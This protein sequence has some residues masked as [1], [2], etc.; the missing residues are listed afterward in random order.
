MF[1]ALTKINP[2]AIMDTIW[3][4]LYMVVKVPLSFWNHLPWYVRYTVYSIVFILACFMAWFTY[5]N[6]AAWRNRS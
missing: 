6:R 4:V 1:E 5:S 2:Q 3:K